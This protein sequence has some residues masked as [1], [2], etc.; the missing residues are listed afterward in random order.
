MSTR[1]CCD[2]K[3]T[4]F[5]RDGRIVSPLQT[6]ACGKRWRQKELHNHEGRI[7]GGQAETCAT[8]K[9]GGCE[10]R[11]WRSIDWRVRDVCS[12]SSR[13]EPHGSCSLRGT[14]AARGGMWRLSFMVSI[15]SFWDIVASDRE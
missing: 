9:F 15:R 10:G 13:R 7:K 2:G 6:E 4:G 3:D 11:G 8:L 14:L 5:G 12:L 1:H